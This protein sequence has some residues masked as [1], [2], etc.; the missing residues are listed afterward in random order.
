VYQL[1]TV[2]SEGGSLPKAE[3]CTS[4]HCFSVR[5]FFKL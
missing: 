4:M 2:V 5:I 1:R 3:L